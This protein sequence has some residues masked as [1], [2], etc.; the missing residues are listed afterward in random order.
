MG[1]EASYFKLKDIALLE[2]PDIVHSTSVLKG[3]LN[4]PKN[5]RIFFT[6]DSFL[7]VWLSNEKYSYHWQRKD[8]VY[9]HDNAPH[10]KHQHIAT[11]PKHFHN[12]TEDKVEESHI[13]DE[14]TI[15]IR[16]LLEFV[17]KIINNQK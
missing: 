4:T 7:E 11:F 15:A 17:R 12:G 14:P 10:K 5:L 9:R 1:T 3:P 6:D 13:T 16:E 2:F 8:S